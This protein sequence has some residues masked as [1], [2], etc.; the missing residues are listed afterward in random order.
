MEAAVSG[1][2]PVIQIPDFV[3]LTDEWKKKCVA[4]LDSLEQV[5]PFLEAMA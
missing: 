5:I 1:G 4:V 3:E 2:I